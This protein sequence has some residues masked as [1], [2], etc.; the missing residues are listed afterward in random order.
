[1]AGAAPSGDGGGEMSELNVTPLVDVLLCL[2]IIFMVSAPKQN[3]QMPLNIPTSAPQVTPG[4]PDAILLIAI[5]A[6][7]KAKLGESPLSDDYDAMVKELKAN[8]KLQADGKVAVD[9]DPKVPYGRVMS[10]MAAAHESG[11]P[12]VGLASNR[13]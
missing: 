9:A 4:D 11:V 5:D 10:V 1:M 3:Q 12:S 6:A 2:L 13:L 8:E 7:G